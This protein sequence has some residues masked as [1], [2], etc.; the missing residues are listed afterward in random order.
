MSR[1]I[2]PMTEVKTNVLM[3]VTFG[4]SNYQ[5]GGIF[6][7]YSKEILDRNGCLH[8]NNMVF[9]IFHHIDYL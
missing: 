9:I 1:I 8:Y 7:E 6:Y 3:T 5:N 4:N 2:L